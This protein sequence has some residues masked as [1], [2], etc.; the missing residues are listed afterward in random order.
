MPIVQNVF[1]RGAAY[2]WRRT[3][4]WA[5][6]HGH[7]I[8]LCLSLKTKDFAVARRRAVALTAR[9]EEV[10]MSL[11]ERGARESLSADQRNAIFHAEMRDYGR[12]LQHLETDWLT[13]PF[14]AMLTD[15]DRDVG[16]YEA[17]WTAFAKTGMIPQ[18]VDDAYLAD[19]L[20]EVED[21]YRVAVGQLLRRINLPATVAAETASCLASLGL[22]AE[23]SDVA[24][25]TRIILYARA[26]AARVH[27]RG[28]WIIGAGSLPEA[29]QLATQEAARA[30]SPG[31][32]D[33]VRRLRLF[34][35][36]GATSISSR[37]PNYSSPVRPVCSSIARPVNGRP[38]RWVNRRY[39]R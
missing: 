23:S 22:A 37:R 10:R 4:T 32:P 34:L 29:R 11:Y 9:S 26:E 8:T 24:A 16:I 36:S 39:V 28:D 19:H 14:T 18:H 30:P 33:Q 38:S 17:V 12:A 15:V 20:P 2:W 7:P 6:G 5:R 31:K 13:D 3:L 25:A 27:R 35:R 21:D 1:R